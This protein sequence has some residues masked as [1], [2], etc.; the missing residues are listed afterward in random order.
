MILRSRLP[1]HLFEKGLKMS[2]EA[3]DHRAKENKS[4]ALGIK[5]KPVQHSQRRQKRTLSN[6]DDRVRAAVSVGQFPPTTEPRQAR[7]NILG[8]IRRPGCSS[9]APQP[10]HWDVLSSLSHHTSHLGFAV[11]GDPGAQ[12]H[13]SEGSCTGS[14]E[15]QNKK[16]FTS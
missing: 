6:G 15:A 2:S 1:S 10:N 8:L 5:S 12:R 7:L 9:R 14:G 16:H 11:F 13:R 3:L 4:E